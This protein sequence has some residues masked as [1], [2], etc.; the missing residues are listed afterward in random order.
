MRFPSF[1][2]V[3][4]SVITLLVVAALGCGEP[5]KSEDI[6]PYT[7][8]GAA[9]TD[10]PISGISA[11]QRAAFDLGDASFELRRRESQGVGPLFIRR[12]CASC[13]NE[14]LRGPGRVQKMVKIDGDESHPDPDQSA[15]PFGE[16]IRPYATAGATEGVTPPEDDDD[17]LITTR[18]P[19]SVLGC[20]YMD[21]VLDSEIERVAALQARRK[22]GIS[23][24]I[25]RVSYD[26]AVNPGDGFHELAPGAKDLIGRFG[27]KAS[28]PT[29]DDFIARAFL[30]DIG[31]TSPLRPTELPTPEGIED[32]DKKGVDIDLETLRIITNYVRMLAI[33]DRGKGSERGRVLFEEVKCAVCHVPSLRTRSDYPIPQLAGIDAPVYTDF[34]LHDRGPDYADGVIEGDAQ[35]SEW[36]TAPL[37]G[38]RY[39][40]SYLHDGSAKT[41]AEAIMSHAAVG[42]ETSVSTDLLYKLSTEDRDELVRFVE[43][44]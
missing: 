15:L 19:A 25:N 6:P 18:L 16:T 41:I 23:G 37:I 5:S 4:V 21:A 35:P 24:R 20:G 40:K 8:V 36:R 1:S 3:D 27:L 33:P 28:R 12:S 29:L 14:G 2:C 34:L 38:L 44:L 17:I 39:F 43:S 11:K 10:V 30:L 13:H 32:D 22:D 26:A 9:P 31:L 42:S 7:L